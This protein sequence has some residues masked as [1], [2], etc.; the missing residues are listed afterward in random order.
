[1]ISV[2]LI[3]VLGLVGWTASAF[4]SKG[5]H[6]SEIKE[7]LKTM[8]N[9]ILTFLNSLKSLFHLL[10]K[11]SIKSAANEDLGVM[12]NNVIEMVKGNSEKR[13]SEEEESNQNAA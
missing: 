6:Q 13:T 8:L 10:I 5:K 1:M 7:E 4:I 12:K 2:A 11:D 3:L 9:L